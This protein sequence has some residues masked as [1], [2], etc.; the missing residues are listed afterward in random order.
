MFNTFFITKNQQIQLPI[1]KEKEI[2]LWIKRED[3]I[4]EFV[5]GN[6]FRKLKYNIQEA[7]K[8]QKNTL[9]TFGGAYSNHIVATAVAGHLSGCETIGVI[10]GEELANNLEKVLR[11]NK[12]L[13][14]AS[15]NGMKFEFVTREEYREKE[16]P[17]FVENL[18]KKH[19]DFY[20]IPEGGTNALA[21]KGCQEIL[22]KEDEKFDYICVAV[23]TGGTISGLIESAKE[24]Q[25]V[26]GFPALKGD[27]LSKDIQKITNKQN[28]ELNTAYHFGG[29][30]KFSTGL[31]RFINEFK[32]KTNILLDPIYTGKM[33]YGIVDLVKKDGFKKGSKILTI[34]TGG[35][36]GIDGANKRLKKKG[37]DL[38]KV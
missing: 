28:W 26:I 32:E 35:L 37:L 29:Y 20:L 31:I 9:L 34:H 3:Q 5:S 16:T 4:H 21:I 17:I 2:E 7:Q 1:L 23:G 38:I 30:G 14:V 10:R 22:T 24:H 19:G 15:E 27:F 33:L 25:K 11:E 18:R 36:Q 8:Q 6:K 13:Q 12:T